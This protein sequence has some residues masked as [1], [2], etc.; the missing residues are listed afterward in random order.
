VGSGGP[1]VTA[2]EPSAGNPGETLQ[3]TIEGANFRTGARVAFGDGITVNVN[4]VSA[5]AIAARLTI[6][7][8]ARLGGRDVTVTNP[9]GRSA[10]L[11]SGFTVESRPPELDSISPA[12]GSPGG[13]LQVT[14]TGSNF[15]ARADVSFGDDIDVTE[16]AITDTSI[17][18]TVTIEL[19]AT[20][21]RDVTVTNPDGRSDTLANA[22][23]IQ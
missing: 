1:T 6:A 14:L 9:D 2:V 7:A 19:G 5:S 15:Q 3:V 11:T 22:F 13:T 23:T 12:F 18:V 16:G 4:S 10:T 21:R 17:V 8:G 20:G